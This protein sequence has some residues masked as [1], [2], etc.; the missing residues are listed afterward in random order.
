[1]RFIASE[2][3]PDKDGRVAGTWTL[4]KAYDGDKV[5]KTSSPIYIVTGGGGA[6]LY[7][8]NLN[9]SPEK[10]QSFTVKYEAKVR[11]MS[12]VDINGKTLTVRQI[13][14]D[15]KELDRWRITK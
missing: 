7:D 1:M 9:D 10:W 14:E 6:S 15:G 11:S 4:D 3:K 13:G 12:S 8:R 2:A 5:T